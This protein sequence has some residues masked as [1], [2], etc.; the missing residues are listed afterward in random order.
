MEINI[1]RFFTENAAPTMTAITTTIDY[2][3]TPLASVG[4]AIKINGLTFEEYCQDPMRVYH[5]AMAD[6][7]RGEAYTHYFT[8]RRGKMRGCFN[9]KTETRYKPLNN[10]DLYEYAKR[11]YRIA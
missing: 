8:A 2:P 9:G 7:L 6:G 10:L 1:T 4:N 3:T 11:K 5:D